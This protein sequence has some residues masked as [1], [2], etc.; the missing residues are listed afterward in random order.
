MLYTGGLFKPAP[1]LTKKLPYFL[2]YFG[3][4]SWVRQGLESGEVGQGLEVWKGVGQ[5]LE[6]VKTRHGEL[7]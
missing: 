1:S 4:I 7:H 5:N 3:V 2:I 6:G